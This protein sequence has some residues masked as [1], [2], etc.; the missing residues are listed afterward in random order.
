MLS[1]EILFMHLSFTCNFFIFKMC[2]C[3]IYKALAFSFGSVLILQSIA[4]DVFICKSLWI[5]AS[6]K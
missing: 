1:F 5:K 4:S 3:I 2:I 6:A